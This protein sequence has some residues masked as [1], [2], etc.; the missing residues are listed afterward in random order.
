[1][2]LA[3][4]SNKRQEEDGKGP[5]FS[6]IYLEFCGMSEAGQRRGVDEEG[7]SLL[8]ASPGSQFPARHCV[9]PGQPSLHRDSMSFT[10]RDV[11]F[12]VRPAHFIHTPRIVQGQS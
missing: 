3:E 8:P 2:G 12:S 9:L 10:F 7:S 11:S 4:H 5:R 1:M 6:E